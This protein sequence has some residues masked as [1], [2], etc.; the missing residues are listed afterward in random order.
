MSA[1]PLAPPPVCEPDPCDSRTTSLVVLIRTTSGEWF[2][3][4]WVAYTDPDFEPVWELCGRDSYQL[5]RDQVVEWID[6]AA[7]AGLAD[8][9]RA[10][11]AKWRREMTTAA[12]LIHANE[13]D[14][15]LASTGPAS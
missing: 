13:V 2:T 1:Q 5:E 14:A 15:L 4:R 8:G 12:N 3:A 6:C 7:V 11:S 9:M 10:L